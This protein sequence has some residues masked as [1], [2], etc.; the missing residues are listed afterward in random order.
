M[1]MGRESMPI[2]GNGSRPDTSASDLTWRSKNGQGAAA[3]LGARGCMTSW[4]SASFP[5]EIAVQSIGGAIS[6]M[7]EALLRYSRRQR[8]A[9]SAR[10]GTHTRRYRG[11]QKSRR[12][13]G[14]ELF[15]FRSR[16]RAVRRPESISNLLI[17]WSG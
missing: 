16:V 5:V 14:S 9:E 4:Q 7:L 6:Q 8:V 17:Q 2:P 3:A 10:K 11:P 1:W 15:V 13:A 12:W